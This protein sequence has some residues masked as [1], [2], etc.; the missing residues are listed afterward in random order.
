MHMHAYEL[1]EFGPEPPKACAGADGMT[2]NG[3]DPATPFT[4]EA[5][6]TCKTMLAAPAT[7]AAL[8][9][10]TIATMKRH[11]IVA[12]VLSGDRPIVAKWRA[13]APER[14]LPAA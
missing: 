6:G 14:F 13:A 12:G 11:N 1:S 10:E 9:A 3:Y 4:F 2:I 8:L 5:L 7:D